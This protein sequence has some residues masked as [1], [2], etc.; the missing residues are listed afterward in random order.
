MWWWWWWWSWSCRWRKTGPPTGLLFTPQE[1]YEHGE[2]WWNDI[3]REMTDS[4]IRT[5]CQSYQQSRLV[6][7]QEELAKEMNSAFTKYVFHTLKNSLTNR[8]ILRLV[9]EFYFPSE[10]RRVEDFD[11]P[12]PDVNPWS[13]GPMASTITTRLPRAMKVWTLAILSL[14]ST[15]Q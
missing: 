4:W 2:P 9:K 7:K 3:E 15:D 10:G 8:K 13:S 11:R 6:A 5:L 14:V 1:I 12:R